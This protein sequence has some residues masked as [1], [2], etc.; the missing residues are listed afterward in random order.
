VEIDGELVMINFLEGMESFFILLG[1][2][3]VAGMCLG[4][5]FIYLFHG[6]GDYE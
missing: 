5:F 6:K 2:G 1:Y 4:C 3:S